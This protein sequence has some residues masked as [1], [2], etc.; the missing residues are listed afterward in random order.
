[1]GFLLLAQVDQTNTSFKAFHSDEFI[2]TNTVDR[3]LIRK[4]RVSL[5]RAVLM[6]FIR[7]QKSSFV[8]KIS[9]R[10]NQ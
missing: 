7:H 9:K 4:K 1:M 8:S 10:G 6:L 2:K 3:V 5:C